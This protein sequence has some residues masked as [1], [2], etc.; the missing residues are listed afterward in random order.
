MMKRYLPMLTALLI[1]SAMLA[2]P[3]AVSV[4]ARS[5]P[6]AWAGAPR[7][8]NDK[9]NRG[10]RKKRERERY[11]FNEHDRRAVREYYEHHRHER[12]F[13]ERDWISRDDDARLRDGYVLDRGLRR[14]CRPLPVVLLREMPPCPPG[15]RYFILGGN[16]VMVDDG[17][18]VRDFIHLD[19]NIPM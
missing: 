18:R 16:V 19:I 14:R 9:E 4:F 2:G 12:Y 7:H 11:R 6:P 5:G 10:Q 13:R 15:Y 1:G 8:D 17:Y 3:G